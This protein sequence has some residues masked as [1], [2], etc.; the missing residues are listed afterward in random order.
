M[1]GNPHPVVMG[2][3]VEQRLAGFHAEAERYRLER[4]A[5]RPAEDRDLRPDVFAVVLVVLLLLLLVK[6]VS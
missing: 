4:L 2:M 3:V 6:E 5:R 1:S